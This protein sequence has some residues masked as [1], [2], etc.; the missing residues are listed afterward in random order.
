MKPRRRNFKAEQQ[1]T[2][3]MQRNREKSGFAFVQ[4]NIII[5]SG[6]LIRHKYRSFFLFRSNIGILNL[7][8]VGAN[9]QN[10]LSLRT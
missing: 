4:C 8:R 3:Q 2:N 6:M 9:F 1:D 5:A 10:T 7:T